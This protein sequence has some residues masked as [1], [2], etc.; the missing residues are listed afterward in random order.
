MKVPRCSEI[1]YFLGQTVH[2]TPG[3]A[4]AHSE[5]PAA[6][7]SDFL[8]QFLVQSLLSATVVVKRVSQHEESVQSFAELAVEAVLTDH[9]QSRD[10]L[11]V[12]VLL[13]LGM[14]AVV[15]RSV[16]HDNS[17]SD[18]GMVLGCKQAHHLDDALLGFPSY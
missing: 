14:A 9:M 16:G 1:L 10:V 8:V 3:V 12:R 11:V 4:M 5:K 17:H 7:V 13:L 6:V 15:E 2:V 18:Q